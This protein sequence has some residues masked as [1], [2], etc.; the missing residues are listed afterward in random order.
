MCVVHCRV[1]VVCLPQRG[2]EIAICTGRS[3]PCCVS[4]LT[5][6]PAHVDFNLV[7]FNGACCLSKRNAV[8]NARTLVFDQPVTGDVTN[9][10]LD[11]SR[12]HNWVLNCYEGE[13]IFSHCKTPEHQTLCGRYEEL[14]KCSYVYL[15][16]HYDRFRCVGPWCAGV[17]GFVVLVAG[18]DLL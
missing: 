10:L 9:L 15:D 14:T 17:I 3:T 4:F 6:F 1:V 13:S 11:L 2:V 5:G 8:T 16:N 12:Q 7:T 18:I